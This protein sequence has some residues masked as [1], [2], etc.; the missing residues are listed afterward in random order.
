MTTRH[1]RGTCGALLLA[2]ATI[3]GTTARAQPEESP[4][5]RIVHFSDLDLNT[6]YGVEVGYRRI[7][8]AARG[9]C[10]EQWS[11]DDPIASTVYQSCLSNAVSAAV[12]AVNR[13]LL[14]TY[15]AKRYRL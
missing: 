7:L 5:T 6:P 3:A 10:G 12:L 8:L 2:L 11:S 1:R 4:P 14:S 15:V 9:A 13:P